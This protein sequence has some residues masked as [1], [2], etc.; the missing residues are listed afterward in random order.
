MVV[1]SWRGRLGRRAEG[2]GRQDRGLDKWLLTPALEE[3]FVPRGKE[4]GA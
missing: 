3:D 1:G 2:E 4:A